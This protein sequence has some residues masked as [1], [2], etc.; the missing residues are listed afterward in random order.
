MI[1]KVG[2]LTM[3]RHLMI[4]IKQVLL[5]YSQQC[6]EKVAFADIAASKPFSG[7]YADIL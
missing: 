2:I 3:F 6:F 1:P 5:L 4:L 7:I